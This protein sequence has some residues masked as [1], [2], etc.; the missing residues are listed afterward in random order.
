MLRDCIWL[1]NVCSNAD[2]IY[3]VTSEAA[4]EEGEVA[5][6]AGFLQAMPV[7]RCFSRQPTALA[8]VCAALLA[9]GGRAGVKT[10]GS[11]AH[12]FS[13]M[14]V[15]LLRPPELLAAQVTVWPPQTA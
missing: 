1:P 15:R 5:G 4:K 12:L 10:A 8:A 7:F 14:A 3:H 13:T 11:I 2:P 6:A 9:S